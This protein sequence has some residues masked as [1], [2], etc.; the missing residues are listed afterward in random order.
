MFAFVAFGSAISA[1]ADQV[2]FFL[3]TPNAAL[4]SFPG[5]YAQVD[6]ERTSLTTATIT[7]T[8]LTNGS[9]I[10]LLGNG[11]SIALNFNGSGVV[12]SGSVIFTGGN[13][14]TSFSG[15]T[16]GNVSD[17]GSFNFI[18]DNFDGFESAVDSLSFNV[19]CPTCN[20]G[21]AADV[22]TAN[23]DGFSVAGHIFVDCEGCTVALATGFAGDGEVPEPASMLLLGTGLLGAAA[24]IRR[25]RKAKK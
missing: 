1:E 16:S 13:G 7:V 4:V 18:L 12:L 20:W 19:S 21:T 8:G 17:F 15:P 25:H 2:T 11:S 3:A 9:N 5:P 24:G 22:L 14:N 6:I 10:Y 23:S